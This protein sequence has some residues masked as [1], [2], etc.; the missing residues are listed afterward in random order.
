MT[1]YAGNGIQKNK[2]DNNERKFNYLNKKQ[3]SYKKI[4]CGTTTLFRNGL[5]YLTDRKKVNI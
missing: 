3:N 2:Q 5:N 4:A 1:Y